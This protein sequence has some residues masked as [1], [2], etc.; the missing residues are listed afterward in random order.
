MPAAKPPG[1]GESPRAAR[2]LRAVRVSRAL[3]DPEAGRA[4][5]VVVGVHRRV[6]H[7][8]RESGRWVILS[9]PDV[10]LAPN[11]VAIEITP[12]GTIAE[13]GFRVG[14]TVALGPG[15]LADGGDVDWLVSLA[16]AASWEPR[17]RVRPVP[18]GELDRRLSVTRAAALADGACESFLPLLWATGADP[19]LTGAARMASE[20]ARGLGV[21]A[22]G[23][24]VRS[25]A[26]AAS[27]LAGLGP[28]LTPSGDDFL[29]GFAAAW[30]LVG[31]SLGFD[32][33]E[34][35]R[36]TH[37]LVSGAR[38]GASPLGRVWLE[39]AVRGELPEP[40][41]RFAAALFA[42]EARDL[43]PA[44]RAMLAVG[45]SSGTDWTVGFL[46]GAAAL[47]D[48]RTGARRR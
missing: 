22:A 3:R 6:C 36:V 24:D 35:R 34:R 39:H 37:A 40:M 42:A 48:S 28:G 33:A 1:P 23:G 30:T 45:A 4:R 21:A 41:T 16:G 46:L 43:G 2:G 47:P 25:V 20:P 13:A 5:A 44:V 31:A 26:G 14:Q 12:A 32:G 9:A 27:R 8:G 29:A 38:A 19:F 15:A 7:L 17:P 18:P 10:P 11:G